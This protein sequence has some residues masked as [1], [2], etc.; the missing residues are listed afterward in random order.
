MPNFT[1][2][3]TSG[4]R[5]LP[6]G[7]RWEQWWQLH[8][9]GLLERHHLLRRAHLPTPQPL[10]GLPRPPQDRLLVLLDPLGRLRTHG[11]PERRVAGSAQARLQ[12]RRSS[13]P[14]PAAQGCLPGLSLAQRPCAL[15]LGEVHRP[16]RRIGQLQ[17][18]TPSYVQC[19]Y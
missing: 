8:V 11:E 2:Q 6:Q 1:P 3:Y 9:G 5:L 7:Q 18:T 14:H 4:A 10:G 12:E 17:D 19:T 16:R 13:A 15:A